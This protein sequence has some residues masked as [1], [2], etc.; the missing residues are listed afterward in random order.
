MQYLGGKFRI[1]REL[2]KVILD[3]TPERSLY[4]EPFIG[5]G[6]VFEHLA[7]HFARAIGSDIHPDLMLMWQ[8]LQDG[9]IPPDSISETEYAAL[10]H[11]EPS[12]L[13][14]FAG[15]GCSFGG[16]WFAGYA[17]GDQKRNYATNARNTLAR[18]NSAWSATNVT[19]R[20]MDYAEFDPAAGA[21]IYCDPPYAE[22]TGY[23]STPS[24]DHPKFW[25]TAARWAAQ[26]CHVFV[27]GY[28]APYA[29]LWAKQ[30]NLE[31]QA[32]ERRTENLYYLPGFS[33][34]RT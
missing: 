32:G 15:F 30:R 6:N 5:G 18:Q 34:D 23:K 29:P 21:V 27:S 31:M 2:S 16:K 9:W 1:A 26:G 19:F 8:A 11:A 25:E 20:C 4:W 28:Q 10:K 3:A 14:G 22:T 12:A 17:R 33:K 7:P 24:F 13:R